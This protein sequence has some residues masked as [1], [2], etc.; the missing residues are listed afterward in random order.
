MSQSPTAS[1]R[2]VTAVLAT[3]LAVMGDDAEPLGAVLAEADNEAT[4]LQLYPPDARGGVSGRYWSHTRNSRDWLSNYALTPQ[5]SLSPSWRSLFRIAPSL[6]CAITERLRTS[7]ERNVTKFRRPLSAELKVAS[8]LMYTG[9]TTCE[10][11]ACQLGIGASSVSA[12]V[13]EV[14]RKIC[15]A[16]SD[17]LRFPTTEAD[18]AQIMSGFEKIRGLP[19]CV[20]A[21][22]GTHVKWLACPMDQFYEYRCYKGY[23]SVVIFAVATANR[24]FIYA[25]IGRPGVLGDSTIYSRSSLK[26]NIDDKTWLGDGIP[27]LVI[28]GI[29]VRPYLVGDC[30]FTLD[31]NMMKTT[32]VREQ[33][34]NPVL[35]TWD[36]IA[37]QT[38]K[39]VECAFGMLKNRFQAL[40]NGIRLQH[41]DDISFVSLA[42]MILHNMSIQ[43]GD[44][45]DDMLPQDEEVDDDLVTAE[46]SAGRRQ[47]DALLYY[48]VNNLSSAHI[49]EN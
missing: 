45:V 30:A 27:D 44:E 26:R 18:V 20:G 34:V 40:K 8:F 33:Q 15:E 12:A 28:S 36:S 23:T 19:Y 46:T 24:R 39:P 21:V 9:G 16:Y 2:Q 48:V 17:E 35:R 4:M 7:L 49:V 29:P 6:F 41:E 31:K 14:S 10:G 32:T 1:R 22:D 5:F 11:T 38:R 13:R 42:C 3:L 37:S 25:D 43:D 47:R